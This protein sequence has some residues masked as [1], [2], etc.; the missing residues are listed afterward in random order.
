MV[1]GLKLSCLHPF[2]GW[3]LTV[4]AD[5][6]YADLVYADLSVWDEIWDGI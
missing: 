3:S 5:L 1:K 4:Y 2:I 6:V